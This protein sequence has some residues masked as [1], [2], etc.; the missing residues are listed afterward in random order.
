[1]SVASLFEFV[2]DLADDFGKYEATLNGTEL[3]AQVEN[4]SC[5]VQ[6]IPTVDRVSINDSEDKATNE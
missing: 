6:R 1:M 3:R 5:N 4:N 2:S